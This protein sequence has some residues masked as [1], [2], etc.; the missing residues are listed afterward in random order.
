M[1]F[2]MNKN[3]MPLVSGAIA[4]FVVSVVLFWVGLRNGTQ[5]HLWPKWA[6]ILLLRPVDIV[7]QSLAGLF[8]NDKADMRGLVFVLPVYITICL[9]YSTIIGLVVWLVVRTRANRKR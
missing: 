4:C 2:V 5:M 9:I 1:V 7:S 6:H 3:R 8:F